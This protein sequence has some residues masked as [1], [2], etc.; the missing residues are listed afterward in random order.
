[1]DVDLQKG[2]GNGE[3]QRGDAARDRRE[4][5]VLARRWRPWCGFELLLTS[6]RTAP[7]IAT[8]R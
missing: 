4:L 6:F 5:T 8:R 1:M 2:D 3:A 7:S